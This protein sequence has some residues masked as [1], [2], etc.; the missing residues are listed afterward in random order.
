MLVI[1]II[2]GVC[3]I[4]FNHFV[5]ERRLRMEDR[6]DELKELRQKHLESLINK[7]EGDDQNEAKN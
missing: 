5:K 7:K 4:I 3:L 2:A 1:A 6:R